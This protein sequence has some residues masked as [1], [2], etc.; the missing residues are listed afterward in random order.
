MPCL[1]THSSAAYGLWAPGLLVGWLAESASEWLG[2][3]HHG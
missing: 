1:H 2:P 3:M